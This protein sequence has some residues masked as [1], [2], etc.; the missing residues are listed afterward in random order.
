MAM[1]VLPQVKPGFLTSEFWLTV[2]TTV[3][4]LL[5]TFGYLTP[6]MADDFIQAVVSVVGGVLTVA[7]TVTYIVG[8]FQLKRAAMVSGTQPTGLL[9]GIPDEGSGPK[10][11][12]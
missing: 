5:V 10:I 8:R 1:T 9:E 6:E 3:S 12:Q 4:G 2:G 11:V 7:A